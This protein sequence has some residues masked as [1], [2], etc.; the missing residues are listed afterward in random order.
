LWPESHLRLNAELC[1]RRKSTGP[2]DVEY[3]QRTCIN[4]V[5]IQGPDGSACEDTAGHQPRIAS[6][7]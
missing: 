6:P 2:I 1:R 4:V 3:N 7:I 5:Q